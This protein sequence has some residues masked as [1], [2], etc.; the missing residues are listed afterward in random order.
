MRRHGWTALFWSIAW[1]VV[2]IALAIFGWLGL[3]LRPILYLA[4]LALSLYYAYQTYSGKDFT[5][6]LV[7]DWAKKYAT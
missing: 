2:F 5:I 1:A 6:P 3:P 4:W 7:S